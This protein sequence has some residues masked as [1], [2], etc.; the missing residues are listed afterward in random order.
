MQ[1]FTVHT[2]R[3]FFKYYIVIFYLLALYNWFS[4]MF[5]YQLHPILF[6][7]PFDGTIWLLMQTGIHQWLLNNRAGCFFFDI[8]FYSFPLV[9]WWLCER[10]QIVS[11]LVLGISWLI[12]NWI[13]I[14]CYVLFPSNSIEGHLAGLL[15]PILFATR[16]TVSFYF[17]LHGIRYFFLFFFVSAGLWKIRT[18]AIFNM[19]QMSGI[20]LM[21]HKEFLIAGPQHWYSSFI[22]W[23]IRNPP[24]GYFLYV[25]STALELIFLIGFFT[26]KYDKQLFILF[27][28]FLIMDFM[29]MHIPYF[30]AL[31]LALPLLFSKQHYK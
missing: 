18:G 30:V 7:T 27:I 15:L 8:I 22:Y 11:P 5:L 25:I 3:L 28:L 17:I 14:L 16:R 10:K 19:D 13:Y 20:L 21:Q 23:I 26:K 29:I 4:G 12:F 6:R 24:I 9:Y 31:P 2:R 1:E